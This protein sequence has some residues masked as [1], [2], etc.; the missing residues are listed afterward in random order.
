MN[1]LFAAWLLC[2][3]A[4]VVAV[5]PTPALADKPVQVFILAGQS[6]MVGHGKT[7]MGLDPEASKAAGRT[8]E[9]KGG[10]GCLRRMVADHPDTF[11]PD[12]TNPLVDANGDWLV[13]DDVYVYSHIEGKATKGGHTT[14]F[15]K[16][17]WN[18]PEYGFG[19]VVGNALDE[20]V[21]IIKYAR[22]GTSLAKDWRPPSAVKARGG[23]VGFM[24]NEMRAEV[25]R[26]LKNLDQEF[27][28]F[29]GRKYEIVGFGWHQGF[30]D[31]V[32][33]DFRPEYEANLV[34]LI[35][36][37][38]AEFKSPKLPFVIAT[39]S[40]F[41]PHT[42]LYE[43]EAAQLA[44]A[45]AKKHPEFAGTVAAVPTGPFW[46]DKSV[47]PSGFGYHWNHNGVTHYQIG[48]AMGEAMLKLP[49]QPHKR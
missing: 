36:D 37:V 41:P 45:D 48:A 18:G 32:S 28:N 1:R 16:G 4:P 24:W 9:V 13:R 31:H 12:G 49:A 14:K 7:E 35:R 19:Q 39:T 30:N 27:P 43:V 23:E 40:M 22:G 3:V 47:S 2:A 25:K 20:D 21:L 33:K 11:G 15:G 46:Q 38:R 17:S 8:V 5:H 6:N 29:A 10:L 34:D 44:V 26:V 42:P